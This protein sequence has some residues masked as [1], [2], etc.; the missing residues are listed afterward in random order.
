MI[1]IFIISSYPRYLLRWNRNYKE[2]KN[3]YH[4]CVLLKARRAIYKQCKWV[5]FFWR[6]QSPPNYT[7]RTLTPSYVFNVCIIYAHKSQRHYRHVTMQMGSWPKCGPSDKC[8][9]FKRSLN[10]DSSSFTRSMASV[11]HGECLHL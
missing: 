8:R 3:I 2:K 6:D 1:Y 9:V 7:W 11:Q 10:G 5:K 4:I